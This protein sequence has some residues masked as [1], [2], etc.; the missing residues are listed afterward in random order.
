MPLG[1]QHAPPVNPQA[2][3]NPPPPGLAIPQ[4]QNNPPSAANPEEQNNHAPAGRA[5]PWAQNVLRLGPKY[6]H[7]PANIS[8]INHL[9]LQMFVPGTPVRV[10]HAPAN[11][12]GPINHGGAGDL[13]FRNNPAGAANPQARNYP[14]IQVVIAARIPAVPPMGILGTPL[15]MQD[16]SLAD[17]PGAAALIVEAQGF[18]YLGMAR[19]VPHIVSDVSQISVFF[20]N[21]SDMFFFNLLT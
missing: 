21:N 16:A 2:Q 13:E 4:A 1:M 8:A 6:R 12:Q 7:P 5:N 10:Q 3:N 20:R 18:E 14:A 15:G 11:V 17:I 19:R 9:A